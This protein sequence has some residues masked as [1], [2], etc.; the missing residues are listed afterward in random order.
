LLETRSIACTDGGPNKGRAF[1]ASFNEQR[2]DVQALF[3][4]R[5]W[6]LV[7][8][9]GEHGF[10]LERYDRI[11]DFRTDVA[12]VPMSAKEGEGLQ[13]LLTVTV[14]LAERFLEDRLTDTLGDAEGTI[15]EM[16]DEVGMSKTIDVILSRGTLRTGD[17]VVFAT[18]DGPAT[19]RIKG[20]K[21]PRGMAEMRDAGDR[22]E[23]V[24]HVDAACGV[25]IVAQGLERA[26]AGTTV[27]LAKDE[28]ALE[29]AGCGMPRGM[30]SGHRPSGGG[31]GRQS[32]YHRWA[33]S[34]CLRT[35]ATRNPDP[36][37]HRRTREQAGHPDRRIRQDPLNRIIAGFSISPNREV[38]DRLY[39]ED[40]PVKFVAGE[41]IYHIIDEIE[42]WREETKAAA[43]AAAR[44]DLVHPGRLLY[45]EN[46]TFRG[47]DPA[48]IGVRVVGGRV[49]I[50]QR[51][52][53]PD[54]SQVGQV[55]S[56]RTRDSE[57][58]REANQGVRWLVP[59]RD[60]PLVVT[61]TRATSSL[62]TSQNPMP[63][64]FGKW[65]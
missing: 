54:G 39:A 52:M 3:E 62:S 18:S 36:D 41:I 34:A 17:R 6:K 4:D 61:S 55:K 38:A 57:D 44:E 48:I 37:G 27:R 25:K 43:E 33:R 2:K 31:R 53:R 16:K 20:L 1:I 50:G 15:L 35:W 63:D 51:L 13:D 12:L 8:M 32:R 58:V 28:E 11:T 64:V 59:F 56:L 26:L 42:T 65:S 7:G 9:F 60:P 5:F 30:P 40:A 46:H 49:H 47:R 22:W 10:N 24:G 45:L 29:K 23:T 14:G 21:R 19:T